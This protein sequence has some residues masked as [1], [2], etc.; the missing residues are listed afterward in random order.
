LNNPTHIVTLT[1]TKACILQ[2][3]LASRTMLHQWWTRTHLRY[4]GFLSHMR[5]KSGSYASSCRNSVCNHRAFKTAK[6]STTSEAPRSSGISGLYLSLLDSYP[7]TTK[8]VTSGILTFSAD[9][10]CQINFPAKGS[11]MEIFKESVIPVTVAN[12]EKKENSPSLFDYLRHIDWVRTGNFT[13]LGIVYIA[14]AMHYWYGF[15]MRAFHGNS[16]RITIL[17]TAM[18]QSMF[19]PTFLTFFFVNSSAIEYITSQIGRQGNNNFNEEM[20]DL[21]KEIQGNIQK[22]LVD[23]CVTNWMVWIPSMLICFKYVPPNLQVLWS[24]SI[25]FFWNIYLSWTLANEHVP[26]TSAETPPALTTSNKRN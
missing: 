19:A 23:T 17:R 22:D 18:D 11:R 4:T 25:G 21:Y 26:P 9:I 7:L 1:H 16:M 20:K 3:I 24:N 10:I 12:I 8:A 5:F 2:E 6:M 13:L 15:L 14:P